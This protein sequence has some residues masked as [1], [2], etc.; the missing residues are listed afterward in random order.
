MRRKYEK[1][2][3]PFTDKDCR[4]A[5]QDENQKFTSYTDSLC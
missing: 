1:R 3:F 2:S 4:E 5:K